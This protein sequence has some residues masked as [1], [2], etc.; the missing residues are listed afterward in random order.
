MTMA[1]LDDGPVTATETVGRTMPGVE[2]K[3][4]GPLGETLSPGQEG[5]LCVRGYN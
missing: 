3:V 2:L 5:E 1:R 4:I